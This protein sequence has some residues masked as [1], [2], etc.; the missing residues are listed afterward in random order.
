MV[1][2]LSKLILYLTNMLGTDL[3]ANAYLSIYKQ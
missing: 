3:Y 1:Q 2:Y